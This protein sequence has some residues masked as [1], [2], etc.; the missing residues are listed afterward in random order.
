MITL[1]H[2]QEGVE[3]LAFSGGRMKLRIKSSFFAIY[4]RKTSVSV[5]ADAA[6]PPGTYFQV[7]QSQSH[8]SNLNS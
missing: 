5:P 2:Q 6:S 3:I 7:I 1:T 8:I 4:G